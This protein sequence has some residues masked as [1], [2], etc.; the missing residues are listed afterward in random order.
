MSCLCIGGV[1]IPYTAVLPLLLIGL[2]WVATQLAKV[3][4]LPDW[5]AKKLA[6]W[7]SP[8]KQIQPHYQLL[9]C[10][11]SNKHHTFVTLDVDGDDCD[12]LSSKLKVAMMP[13][14]ICFRGGVEVG[15]MSG[16]NSEGKL[17]D[18]V[19]EMCS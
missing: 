4:L 2:Q 15:R 3:G 17:T 14:F 10:K 6:D 18:W 1:C 7:C 19:E 16:G 12:S 5:V 13:T 11:F 8:C 9:S